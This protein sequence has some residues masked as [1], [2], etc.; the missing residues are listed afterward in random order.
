MF[1][2]LKGIEFDVD[3]ESTNDVEGLRCQLQEV[4]DDLVNLGVEIADQPE[5]I[6]IK[7]PVGPWRK[8]LAFNISSDRLGPNELADLIRL[9]DAVVF[10]RG[11]DRLKDRMA[12]LGWKDLNWTLSGSIKR[13]VSTN[14]GFTTG[15]YPTPT[16]LATLEDMI[17]RSELAQE[18][19]EERANFQKAGIELEIAGHEYTVVF[20][21]NDPPLCRRLTRANVDW[22]LRI[23]RALTTD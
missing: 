20:Q 2:S 17:E 8:E 23:V 13:Q 10:L 22:V 1:K 12:V 11:F 4:L 16:D 9:R 14:P 7:S 6:H 21:E 19:H 18:L 5:Y 15:F 3:A